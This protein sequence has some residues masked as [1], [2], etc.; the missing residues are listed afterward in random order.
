MNDFTKQ[1]LHMSLV[2]VVDC[3]D[4]D[5]ILSDACLSPGPGVGVAVGVAKVELADGVAAPTAGCRVVFRGDL[6]HAESLADGG[7]AYMVDATW[8]YVEPR[9]QMEGFL[10]EAV[11]ILDAIILRAAMVREMFTENDAEHDL[12]SRLIHQLAAAHVAALPDKDGSADYDDD[13]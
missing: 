3:G 13:N 11:D 12:L 5:L 2:G 10:A 7:G 8:E 4:R 1:N 9:D 6:R